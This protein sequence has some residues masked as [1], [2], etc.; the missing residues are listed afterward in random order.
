MY[1]KNFA[2]DMQS[3]RNVADDEKLNTI[4]NNLQTLSGQDPEGLRLALTIYWYTS[5]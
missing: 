5:R 4:A 2:Y 1:L 3:I